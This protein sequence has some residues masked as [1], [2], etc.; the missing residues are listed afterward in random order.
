VGFI[1]A[2]WATALEKKPETKRTSSNLAILESIAV[3]FSLF[4]P[5]EAK[6]KCAAFV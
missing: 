3:S 4:F 6:R 5:V 1:D 2:L